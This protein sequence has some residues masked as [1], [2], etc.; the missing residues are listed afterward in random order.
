MTTDYKETKEL[1]GKLFIF[2]VMVF[3]ESSLLK[4]RMFIR[5]GTVNVFVSVIYGCCVF[6]IRYFSIM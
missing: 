4:F 1:N 5:L 2:Y 3:L 6:T